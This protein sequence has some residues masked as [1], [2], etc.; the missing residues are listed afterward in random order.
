MRVITLKDAKAGMRLARPVTDPGG[1]LLV[2]EGTELS[3]ESIER[4]RT[5]RIDSICVEDSAAPLSAEE[6]EKTIASIDGDIDRMFGEATSNEV[7]KML[8]EYAKQF[9]KAKVK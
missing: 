2:P 4:L 3:P 5:R 8:A 7:M 1:A 6:R 9:L